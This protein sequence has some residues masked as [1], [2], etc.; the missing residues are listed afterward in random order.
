MP[1][2]NLRDAIAPVLGRIPS[3]VSI[4]IAGDGKG[5]ETGMLA[6]WVQQCSFDPPMLTIAVN[7][8]RYLND[9]LTTNAPVVLSLLGEND[10]QLLKHF[11]QG[12]EPDE[13]QNAF[14]GLNTTP[15]SNGLP[16]LSKALGT[17]EGK[18]VSQIDAGDHYVYVAEITAAAAGENLQSAKPWVH[19]RKSGLNY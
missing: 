4:L 1:D 16:T 14:A 10:A 15:A 3:G 2:A 5:R 9:W 13:K 8:K 12:F 18:V 17:L 6:S 19:I 7:K 11:S